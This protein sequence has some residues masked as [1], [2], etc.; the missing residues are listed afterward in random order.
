M[1]KGRGR[2]RGMET[3]GIGAVY[4]MEGKWRESSEFRKGGK[5]GEREMHREMHGKRGGE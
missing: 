3:V 1:C 5:I 2:D 4:L